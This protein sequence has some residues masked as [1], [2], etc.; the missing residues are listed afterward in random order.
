MMKG[1]VQRSSIFPLVLTAMCTWSAGVAHSETFSQA[2]LHDAF[3][4]TAFGV[5]LQDANSRPGIYV[6]KFAA[7]VV[8]AVRSTD[9]DLVQEIRDRMSMLA[10][11]TGLDLRE[12]AFEQANYFVYV[13][14]VE[15]KA[16]YNRRI[17]KEQGYTV[18]EER[19]AEY[20]HLSCRFSI[21]PDPSGTQKSIVFLPIVDGPDWSYCLSEELIQAFGLLNDADDVARSVMNDR[22]D[23][24]NFAVFDLYLLRML[25]DDRIEPGMSV[26]DVRSVLDDDFPA[27]LQELPFIQAPLDV[28]DEHE[29]ILLCQPY[30]DD[31]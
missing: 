7:P 21:F 31:P 23:S 5:E 25:A 22:R 9:P 8:Y 26:D 20:D 15:E 6:R 4:K 14:P 28:C 2:D 13:Y 17:M 27:Q 1:R 29:G 24:Q 30:S 11:L 18:S 19:L 16:A 3:L 10:E 12:G